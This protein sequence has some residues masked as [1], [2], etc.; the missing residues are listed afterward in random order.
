MKFRHELNINIFSFNFIRT[1]HLT[2]I[3]T[4]RFFDYGLAID[5]DW[6]GDPPSA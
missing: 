3:H 6:T 2:N 1:F 5:V 4:I